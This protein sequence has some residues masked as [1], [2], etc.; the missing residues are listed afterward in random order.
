MKKLASCKLNFDGSTGFGISN[1]ASKFL[2]KP[3]EV[4][5]S[6]LHVWTSLLAADL[7]LS[8]KRG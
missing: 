2:L 4:R 6:E 7:D 5:S 8:I 3:P 1:L